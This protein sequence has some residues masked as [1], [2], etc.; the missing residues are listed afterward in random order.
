MPTQVERRALQRAMEFHGGAEGLAQL[1]EVPPAQVRRWSDGSDPVP[2]R[3][4]MKV[5]DLV[6]EHDVAELRRN[7]PGSALPTPPSGARN[8]AKMRV[9]FRAN[10]RKNPFSH[11]AWQPIAHPFFASSFAPKNRKELL[12]AALDAALKVAGTDLANIQ[13]VDSRGRLRIDAQHGFSPPFLEFF[14]AVSADA[15]SAYGVALREQRQVFVPDVSADPMFAGTV[16]GSIILEAGV[17]ALV[18]SPI[19]DQSGIVLG[20]LSTHYRA[21]TAEQA[22]NLQGQLHVA[23]RIG[24]W[25]KAE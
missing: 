3:V 9:R 12:S 11:A 23:E 13:I 17:R 25:L 2:A 4:F 5:V 16:S 6:I 1:L 14:R 20:M 15:A 24:T 10:A 21:P 7:V 18:S 8:E 22:A 19:L